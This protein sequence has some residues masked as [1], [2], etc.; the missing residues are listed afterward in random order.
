MKKYIYKILFFT[1]VVGA[2][3]SCEVEEFNDLNNAEVDAFEENLTRGDLQ[4]LVGGIL[5]SSR[6]RLGTYFDDCGVVG[7]EYY[8]FSGSEPRFTGDLLGREGLTLD[9]NTF[10]I[11]GPWGARYRTV[12]N[13]NLILGFIEGQDLSAQF[14]TAE[15]TGTKGFLKTFIAH[16]LLLNLNLTDENG[17][18]LDVEDENNLGPFVSKSAALTGIRS[19]LEEAATDL[20]NGGPDFPFIVSSGFDGFDTPSSF[21]QV[22]KAISARVAAYQGD[23]PAVLSFLDDSFFSLDESALNTGLFYN[24]SL[25]QT[26]IVNPLF[27]SIDGLTAANARIVQPSF[28]S[29]AEANDS[30]LNKIVELDEPLSQDDLSG[31]YAVFRYKTNVDDIPLIRN[32]ELILLYAEANIN[33]NPAETVNALNIIRTSA[34]LTP[35]TGPTDPASLT[36][37]MLTQR[38]Y[39]LYA[40]GHRWIDMR[41]FDRLDELPIDRPDDDVFSQF[42]IPLTENQ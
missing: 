33:S 6:V 8:R 17:I 28:V 25:D 31:N 39:S 34:G 3:V 26:D 24:F 11:T 22:N 9:N 20:A 18:R 12:K 36:D 32:E 13:A 41:R 42:P 27:L 4:D 2:L 29:D 10:Y 16:E 38:R 40:E 7:R 21:L 15:L 37:E 19:L 23:Y 14:S 30:R 1:S 5:Y 35:Y